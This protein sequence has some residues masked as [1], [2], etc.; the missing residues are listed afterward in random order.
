MTAVTACASVVIDAPRQRVWEAL[1]DPDLV[2]QYFMGAEVTDADKK[3]RD[4]YEKN[5]RGVLEGLKKV[6]EA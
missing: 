5:W 6:S 4:D 3:S 1:T 2:R